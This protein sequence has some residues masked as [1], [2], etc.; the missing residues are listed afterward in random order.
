M[1]FK[2]YWGIAAI[3]LHTKQIWLFFVFQK[4]K[5]KHS[6]PT[7]LCWWSANHREWH[8]YDK[9]AKKGL[10]PKLQD[11]KLRCMEVFSWNRGYEIKWKDC[12][13][14]MEVNVGFDS[15]CGVRR[16]KT[17]EYASWI[18]SETHF[19][20]VWWICTNKSWWGWIDNWCC[21]ISMTFGK[22]TILDQYTTRHNVCSSTLKP[23]H[24][25]TQKISFGGYFSCGSIHKKNP[26]QGI[27]L[28]ASS[29][30]QLI[31]FCDSNW[32]SCP[33]SKRSVTSFCVK[34]GDSLISWK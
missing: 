16:S 14:S 5:G 26:G 2:T 11:E 23:V 3:R 22:V 27:L 25:Q 30:P 7:Y 20:W 28:A 17:N 31:A 34:L 8:W 29:K 33:M 6:H 1:E 21:S 10:T 19:D 24:A 18:K 15:W 32:A 13:E 12:V 4:T 9:W